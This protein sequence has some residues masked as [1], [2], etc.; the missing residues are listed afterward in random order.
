MDSCIVSTIKGFTSQKLNENIQWLR[1]SEK[2]YP[3]LTLWLVSTDSVINVKF[4]SE[5]E[6]VGPYYNGEPEPA[7]WFSKMKNKMFFFFFHLNQHQY[8]HLLQEHEGCR[9]KNV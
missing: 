4:I 8:R 2:L 7:P 9:K 1:S 6:E 5:D 3:G